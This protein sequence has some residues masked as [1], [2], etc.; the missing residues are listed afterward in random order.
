MWATGTYWFDF[1]IV[2][3]IYAAGNILMG[4]FEE[5]T[6]KWR[7]ILKYLLTIIIVIAITHYFGRIWSYGLL[8][9]LALFIIYV[10]LIALPAK[11]IN[12]W[13]GEPREKYY[14]F[15]G[16]DK[17]RLYRERKEEQ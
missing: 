3:F 10:H 15:R 8:S 17:S 14:E 11:G 1:S 7:R 5:H 9:A 12:G 6:P 4:H 2:S 16:W 13:T